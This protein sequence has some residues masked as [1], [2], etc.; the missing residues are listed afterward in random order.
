MTFVLQLPFCDE[1]LEGAPP[2]FFQ[3]KLV[4]SKLGLGCALV[5]LIQCP[6]LKK[7]AKVLW[8]FGVI[9]LVWRI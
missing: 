9:V 3:C 8:M 5:Q 2:D 6:H 7:H 4:L 1:L